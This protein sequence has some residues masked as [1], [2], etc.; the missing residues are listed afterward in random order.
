MGNRELAASLRR[1]VLRKEDRES[2]PQKRDL[3]QDFLPDRQFQAMQPL[4][5]K[6]SIPTFD[7]PPAVDARSKVGHE[8]LFSILDNPHTL[9]KVCDSLESC[10]PHPYRPHPKARP[11]K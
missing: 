6:G 9:Q 3:I 7:F 10:R 11:P 8:R 5:P 2:Y 1:N 4:Y